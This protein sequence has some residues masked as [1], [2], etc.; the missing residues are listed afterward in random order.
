[1]GSGV[2]KELWQT[3]PNNSALT[4]IGNIASA[5]GQAGQQQGQQQ[6]QQPTP[7]V[8]FQMPQQPYVQPTPPMQ[9]PFAQ[10]QGG[11]P[12]AFYGG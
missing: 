8:N 3:G 5:W 11:M 2:G 7:P 4:G 12:N 1:M 6:Q 9:N 10:Q